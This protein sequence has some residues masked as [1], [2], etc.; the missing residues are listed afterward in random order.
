MCLII[1]NLFYFQEQD[2]DLVGVAGGQVISHTTINYFG[3][4]YMSGR[5]GP[6]GGGQC[7]MIIK[8]FIE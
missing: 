1:M 3:P 6:G 7:N 5:R 4:S 2:L 8:F